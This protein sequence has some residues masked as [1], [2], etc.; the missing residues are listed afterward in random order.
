VK[1]IVFN[2]LEQAVIDTH[3][4][5]A[6]E[7]IVEASGVDGAYT[8]VGSYPDDD[9]AALV[10]AASDALGAPHD[11]VVRWFGRAALPMLADRYPGFFEPHK[12]TR[13]FL[14]TL[15]DVIHPEVRKLFPGSYAP[16]FEF[17]ESDPD[18]LRL[19]YESHRH[20]CAFG[21]GLIIGSAD[22]YNEAV[23]LTQSSCANRGDE[24]C[25]FVCSF[26]PR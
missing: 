18:V 4:E 7:S 22:H 20:L 1:G 11:D 17:D 8:A 16:S 5:D 24:K 13:S 26:S 23:E 9:L 6:W 10:K 12:D 2:L 19:G 3:G 25:V 14:L 21:E 15:N